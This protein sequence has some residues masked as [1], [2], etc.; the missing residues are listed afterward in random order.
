MDVAITDIAALSRD[1][2]PC[3]IAASPDGIFLSNDAAQTWEPLDSWRHGPTFALGVFP[4][5]NGIAGLLAGTPVGV[6]RSL[7][8]GCSWEPVLS[9]SPVTT[10]AI[11]T[12][13]LNE[14]VVLVGTESDGILRSMD[15]GTHWSEANPGILD[16]EILCLAMSPNFSI[17]H[18]AIAGTAS[19][20]YRSR[21]GG[22]A[23]R[24]LSLGVNDF[25]VSCVSFDPGYGSSGCVWAG[26]EVTGLLHSRD[27]G[28]TWTADTKLCPSGISAIAI[29]QQNP[30]LIYIAS[31]AGMYRSIDA[32]ASWTLISQL[33]NVLCLT[34]VDTG[35][36]ELVLAGTSNDGILRSEDSGM[37][38]NP[39]AIEQ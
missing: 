12:H 9:S 17:D 19:G 28:A 5:G 15:S 30:A 31:G 22:Q 8:A 14:P 37:T 33:I 3:L 35:G 36:G 32:G 23:W 21:N 2:E 26:T 18:T 20:L 1:C 10:V 29:S 38:W 34:I 4:T 7:D 27:G 24:P 13:P 39:T 16:Y 11:E 25:A 6:M